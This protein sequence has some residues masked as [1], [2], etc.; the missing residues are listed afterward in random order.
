MWKIVKAGKYIFHKNDDLISPV[1]VHRDGKIT[2]KGKEF[3]TVE[4][5]KKYALEK[6][7]NE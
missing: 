2:Y 4:D 7:N 3:D 6:E 5:A 1:L